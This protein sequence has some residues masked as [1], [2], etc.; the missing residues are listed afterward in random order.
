MAGDIDRKA[1]GDHQQMIAAQRLVDQRHPGRLHEE[2]KDHV[3]KDHLLA[4]R[5]DRQI[6]RNRDSNF[7]HCLLP[8]RFANHQ[9]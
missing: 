7:R 8:R 1:G 4:H 2:G 3:G 5:V 6:L 9:R